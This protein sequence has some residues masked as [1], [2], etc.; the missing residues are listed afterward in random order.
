MRNLPELGADFQITCP[1]T[2]DLISP[3]NQIR[4]RGNVPLLLQEDLVIELKRS[5]LLENWLTTCSLAR[6][7]IDHLVLETAERIHEALCE[8]EIIDEPSLANDTAAFFLLALRQKGVKHPCNLAPCEVRYY[9]A[10]K[11]GHILVS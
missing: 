11:T 8:D 4:A 9:H 3:I 6:K 10:S 5:E 7:R 2:S 1:E